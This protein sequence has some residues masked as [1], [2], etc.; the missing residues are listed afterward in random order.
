MPL[1]SAY[2]EFIS[3][4][5]RGGIWASGRAASPT[6]RGGIAACDEDGQRPLY[7]AL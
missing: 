1:Y 6:M 2:G 3:G 7:N 5:G 4:L